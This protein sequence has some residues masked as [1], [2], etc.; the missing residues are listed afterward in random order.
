MIVKEYL[1]VDTHEADRDL[2]PQFEGATK[3]F[4]KDLTQSQFDRYKIV[5]SRKEFET[6]TPKRS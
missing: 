5:E 6:E 2:P 1:P 3:G 4:S